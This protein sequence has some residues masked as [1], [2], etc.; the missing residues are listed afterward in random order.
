MQRLNA[1]GIPTISAMYDSCG[2]SA[3]APANPFGFGGQFVYYTDAETG[4]ILCQHRYYDSATRRFINRDPIG[5]GGGLNFYAYCAN[6]PINS[7]DPSGFN[8]SSDGGGGGDNTPLFDQL[9]NAGDY[10]TNVQKNAVNNFWAGDPTHLI[11]TL[12]NTVLDL[13]NGLLHI[14]AAIGHVGEGTGTFAGNPTLEN[15]AGVARDVVVVV[16][17]FL[18]IVAAEAAGAGQALRE[19]EPTG[20]ALK[21]DAYHR[22]V[23]FMRDEAAKKGTHFTIVGNDGVPVTLTQVPGGLNGIPGRFE[24]IVDPTGNLTHQLFVPRGT[25][26]GIPIKP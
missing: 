26:N 13:G 17:I 14:P 6:N 18:P 20:S 10:G 11:P 23:T 1:S 24:Y 16:S 3:S 5:Y 15:F 4:A 2:A 8:P 12:M 25:I 21:S 9:A 7:A 22:A 19:E